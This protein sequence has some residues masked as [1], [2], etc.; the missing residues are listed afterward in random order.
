[1]TFRKVVVRKVFPDKCHVISCSPFHIG[2]II[3]VA[4]PS[5]LVGSILLQSLPH[6]WDHFCCSPFHIGGII[7]V[8]GIDKRLWLFG[9]SKCTAARNFKRRGYHGR[10]FQREAI[11]IIGCVWSCSIFASSLVM[12]L[13]G[14]NI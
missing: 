5:T 9:R 10:V 6:W 7:F 8:F 12:R 2:G 11:S 13:K 3:F 4:V 14:G 1:M